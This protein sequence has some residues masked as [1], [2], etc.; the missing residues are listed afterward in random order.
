MASETLSQNEI[1]RLLDG[2]PQRSAPDGAASQAPP[3]EPAGAPATT[4]ESTRRPDAAEQEVQVYDF[5]R[6]HRVSKERLRALEA[7]YGRMTKSFETWL[8]GRMRSPVSLTLQSVEQ[9]SFGE[10]VLS[11]S[12]P[13]AAYIADIHDSG[14]QQGVVAFGSEFA[15]LIVD[16]LLGG[17]GE[18]TIPDRALSAIERLVV[19]KA[20]ERVA[21]YTAECWQDHVPLELRIGGFESVP[22][23][24]QAC[25]PEDPVLVATAEVNVG[26]LSSLVVV[27]LPFVV[28]E[29]FFASGGRKSV[30]AGTGSEEERAANREMNSSLLRSTR[31]SVAARLPELKLTVRDLAALRVGS[32]LATGVATDA[33][34]YLLVGDQPRFTVTHGKAGSRLAVRVLD[35]LTPLS[36]PSYIPHGGTG[37]AP[38]SKQPS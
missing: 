36:S 27:A 37:A 26:E 14:E 8:L 4:A 25:N 30:N 33:A 35:S 2:A 20:A 34:S 17:S 5:R 15:F 12:S 18:P 22:E 31:V 13:C 7:L 28:L 6:P 16:R 38:S 21:I 29:K 24:L 11:L 1:D 23:I 32:I 3:N 9:L 10:F 19:R